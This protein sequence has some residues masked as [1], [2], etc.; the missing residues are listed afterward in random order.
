MTNK[1]QSSNESARKLPRIAT[2]ALLLLF[3]SSF[4]AGCGKSEP[5]RSPIVSG[6]II[7]LK[8]YDKPVGSPGDIS[9]STISEKDGYR[10][11]VFDSFVVVTKPEGDKTVVSHGWYSGLLFK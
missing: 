2:A 4:L 9:W 5:A 10:V 1:N 7:S 3:A 8:I 6:K 11:G